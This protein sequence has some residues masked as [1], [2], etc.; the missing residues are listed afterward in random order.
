MSEN[1]RDTLSPSAQVTADPFLTD[2]AYRHEARQALN[3]YLEAC[4]DAL[5]QAGVTP[6]EWPT[7]DDQTVSGLAAQMLWLNRWIIDFDPSTMKPQLS[8]APLSAFILTKDQI[9]K[10]IEE[11]LPGYRLIEQPLYEQLTAKP[12][13]H[14]LQV[15]FSHRISYHAHGGT[16]ENE[17]IETL[18]T[19]RRDLTGLF[20]TLRHLLKTSEADKLYHSVTDGILQ[21]LELFDILL[22]VDHT[23]PLTAERIDQL[24]TSFEDLFSMHWMLLEQLID[25]DKNQFGSGLVEIADKKLSDIRALLDAYSQQTQSEEAV[26]EAGAA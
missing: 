14:I 12:K 26:D 22:D 21:E 10:N 16:L 23:Q 24:N 5:Q 25:S 13:N 11:I 6:P 3:A 18:S 4:F 7:L 9:Q 2:S 15:D 20:G 17:L 8:P 19:L 1:T